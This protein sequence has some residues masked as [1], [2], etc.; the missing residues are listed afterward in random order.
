MDGVFSNIV[1]TYSPANGDWSSEQDAINLESIEPI[2]AK[3]IDM[4]KN[5]YDCDDLEI[6]YIVDYLTFHDVLR[7]PKP[8]YDNQTLSSIFKKL[9]SPLNT[10]NFQIILT[11]LDI[12]ENW[13]VEEPINSIKI[14][15][16]QDIIKALLNTTFENNYSEGMTYYIRQVP[17]NIEHPEI[18]KIINKAKQVLSSMLGNKNK[19]V[20]Y[21]AIECIGSIGGRDFGAL[22]EKTQMFYTGIKNEFLKEIINLL[23]YQRDFFFISKIEELAINILNFHTNKDIAL[24][25]LKTIDRSNEYIL[26]Q[27]V[28]GVDFLIVDYD[29]FY[30][31]YVQQ[32]DIHNWMFSSIYKMDKNN[33]TTDEHQVIEA[34]SQQYTSKEQ[35]IDL[36]NKLNMSN[37]NSYDSLL[38][39]LK[40]WFSLNNSVITDICKNHLDT[41]KDPKI[42]SVLKELSFDT[43]IVE[44][45][46]NDIKDTSTNDELKVYISSIFKNYASTKLEVLEKI[47]EQVAKKNPDEIRMFIAII[48]QKI[49]FQL[50]KDIT[51]YP[52][53]ESMIIQFFD[54]QIQYHFNV[55]SY[56]IHHSLEIIKEKYGVSDAI[57]DRL[58]SIITS[59]EIQINEFD[60]KAIYRILDL[61]LMDLLQILFDKLTSKKE[62]GYY[63]HYFSQYLDSDG[64]TESLLL[65]HQQII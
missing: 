57:R 16:T 47:I 48:S 1:T 7:L 61:T 20:V 23:Q 41:I 6:K 59:N 15:L 11:T 4:L 45:S 46:A 29:S 35:L 9:V 14:S 3:L 32:D 39:I 27:M 21:I 58:M 51:L 13:L 53:F 18:L 31:E 63:R 26:Y 37:W 10:T 43:G 5:S 42:V 33:I 62:D 64:L 30:A 25:I 24:Q 65:L 17:L 38:K 60:L 34:L 49:Y 44:I 40:L 55:E 52:D 50:S 22:S 56:L 8:Y 12:V 36:L 54:W 2:I 19:Q 28:I